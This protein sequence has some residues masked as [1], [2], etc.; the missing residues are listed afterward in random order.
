MKY[1]VR[2][3]AIM[4]TIVAFTFSKGATDWIN[5]ML[6]LYLLQQEPKL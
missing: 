5:T 2:F 1:T 4:A 6:L 3:L